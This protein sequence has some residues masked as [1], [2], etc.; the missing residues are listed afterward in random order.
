MRDYLKL[1]EI[2]ELAELYMSIEDCN[3]FM[4]AVKQ[5]ANTCLCA[6]HSTSEC[7]CGAWEDDDDL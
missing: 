6:A 1:H 4:E 7:C 3:A 2:E 5:S